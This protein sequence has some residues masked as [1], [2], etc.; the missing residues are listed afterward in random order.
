ME[1]RNY[2]N[3]KA[4]LNKILLENAL[5]LRECDE[6]V[7]ASVSANGDV[8]VFSDYTDWDSDEK[9]EEVYVLNPDE[10]I[11]RYADCFFT[12][13]EIADALDMSEEDLL[14]EVA[15]DIGE[16]DSLE[17]LMEMDDIEQ[18]ATVA[19]Y[20]DDHYN[21]QIEAAAREWIETASREWI[22]DKVFEIITIIEETF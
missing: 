17:E 18:W 13:Q 4:A 15:Q 6:S 16:K 21:E 22:E 11:K 3:V 10:D 9:A 8:K 14:A 12:V 2:N 1:I 19:D 5:E 7:Y 20:V